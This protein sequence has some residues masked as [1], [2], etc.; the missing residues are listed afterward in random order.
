MHVAPFPLGVS[1]KTEILAVNRE[2]KWFITIRIIRETG[3][4]DDW[5]HVNKKL[6]DSIRKQLLAWRGLTPSE[7]SR[8]AERAR[9]GR[10]A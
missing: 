10:G 1:Q 8:Y 5:I 9:G 3:K 7:R 6:A 2:A 4:R